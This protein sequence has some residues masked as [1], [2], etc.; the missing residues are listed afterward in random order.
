M[1]ASQAASLRDI[2]LLPAN[3][4]AFS[5]LLCSSIAM[6]C[7][8]LGVY[9]LCYHVLFAPGGPL[10]HASLDFNTRINYSGF[11]AVAAVQLVIASHAIL[12]FRQDAKEQEAADAARAKLK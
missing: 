6:V 3:R 7:V 9:F 1:A 10:D 4:P 8:P 5:L 2:V 11:A 12:A